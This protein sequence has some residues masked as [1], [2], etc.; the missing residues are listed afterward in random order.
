MVGDTVFGTVTNKSGQNER[1][2]RMNHA[3]MRGFSL[4]YS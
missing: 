4:Y 1:V 3:E 2:N